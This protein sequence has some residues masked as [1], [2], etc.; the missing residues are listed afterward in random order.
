MESITRRSIRGEERAPETVVKVVLEAAPS[1]QT[2]VWASTTPTLFIVR[3]RVLPGEVRLVGPTPAT[4][5]LLV[6]VTFP[7]LR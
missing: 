5:P 2:V 1:T 7:V 6:P 3:I 4:R